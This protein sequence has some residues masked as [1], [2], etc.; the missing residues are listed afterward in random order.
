VVRTKWQDIYQ[1]LRE[2]ILR[3][4]LKP[5]QAFP[6]NFELMKEFNAHAATVQ[7]AVN[8]LIREG[9]VFSEENTTKKRTVRSIPYRSHRRGDF[10]REHHDISNEMI[11]QLKI[12]EH[13]EELPQ[14]IRTEI[15]PPVLF[16]HTQQLR[17]EMIVT[18]A[19]SYITNILPLDKLQ[20]RLEK[21][22]AML[23]RTMKTLGFRSLICDETL[24]SD[25]PSPNETDELQIPK[26]TTIPIVRIQRKVFDHREQL[27]Q[28][29]WMINRADCYEFQYRFRL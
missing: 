10:I 23:Y 4:E 3:G 2:R 7:N 27:L 17:D 18:I 20:S 22:H 8:A 11:I 6:T 19:R 1:Q 5:G 25:L 29:C 21:S 14:S 28:I 12:I 9:L 26:N 16:S 15:Q 13:E 24:V